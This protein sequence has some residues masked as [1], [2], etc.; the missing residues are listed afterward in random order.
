M[1]IEKLASSPPSPE[2]RN[3]LAF[4]SHE[5]NAELEMAYFQYIRSIPQADVILVDNEEHDATK[6]MVHQQIS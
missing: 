2:A 1:E 4:L 3:C 6:D 5:L